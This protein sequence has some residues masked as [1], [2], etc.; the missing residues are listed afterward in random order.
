MTQPSQAFIQGYQAARDGQQTDATF[1]TKPAEY[2]EGFSAGRIV[3]Q[4]LAAG[5]TGHTG[6]TVNGTLVV[7]TG[8]ASIRAGIAIAKLQ[9]A[10]MAA[11]QQFGYT[12]SDTTPGMAQHAAV[13]VAAVK[14][15]K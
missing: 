13:V 5:S 10:N 6:H 9:L 2:K 11:V 15:E 7:D 12:L 14:G 1:P 4:K 8:D 3:N